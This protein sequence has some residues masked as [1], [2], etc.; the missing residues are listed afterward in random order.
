M[1]VDT[2]Q[3]LKHLKY[4]VVTETARRT[5]LLPPI[6]NL[7]PMRV[8][9]QVTTVDPAA[10]RFVRTSPSS[11]PPAETTRFSTDVIVPE[12]TDGDNSL[13]R[14]Q[15]P[16]PKDDGD[17]HKHIENEI[18]PSN[19]QGSRIYDSQRPEE[20]TSENLWERTEVLAGESG[21]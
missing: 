18:V 9:F 12:E 10:D 19:G 20:V 11:P 3:E 15:L 14:W 4:G 6:T 1:L 21:F 5:F 8:F 13:D 17:Q 16:T 7:E 2:E